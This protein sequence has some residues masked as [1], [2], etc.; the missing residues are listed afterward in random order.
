MG[1]LEP[2]C[3]DFDKSNLKSKA[4]STLKAAGYDPT[5]LLGIL[6][7]LSYEHP[8]WAKAISSE[9]IRDLR[10]KLE[11]EVMPPIGYRLDSS[12]FVQAHT[13]VVSVLPKVVMPVLMR[14]GRN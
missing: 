9:D 10:A 11:S 8:A 2:I 12:D 3:F 1:A 6:S 5:S 14:G 13:A 4:V 7:K